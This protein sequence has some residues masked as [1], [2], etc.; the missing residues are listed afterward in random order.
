[1]SSVM[2]FKVVLLSLVA[3]IGLELLAKRL[4]LPPAAALLVGGA[5]MAF[6]PGLHAS[7]SIPNWS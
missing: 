6:V 3:I 4:R 1:M 2:G 7:I 5:A